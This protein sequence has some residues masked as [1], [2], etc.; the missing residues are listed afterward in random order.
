MSAGNSASSSREAAARAMAGAVGCRSPLGPQARRTR[1]PAGRIRRR[2]SC[3]PR[4]AQARPLRMN[5]RHRQ[6]GR[7]TQPV[8]QHCDVY[9]SGCASQGGEGVLSAGEARI[10]PASG[11]KYQ[12]SLTSITAGHRLA[13]TP[14]GASKVIAVRR[15]GTSPIGRAPA[16]RPISSAHAPAALTTRSARNCRSSW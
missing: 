4:R 1:A 7:A 6:R 2:R 13:S 10:R 11:L 8:D 15:L 5:P 14:A 12:V 16:S 9:S 3:H